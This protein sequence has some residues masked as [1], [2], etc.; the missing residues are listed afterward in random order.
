MNIESLFLDWSL[1][2]T[3]YHGTDLFKYVLT[4]EVEQRTLVFRN[5]S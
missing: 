5:N 2:V 1:K 4:N 3:F